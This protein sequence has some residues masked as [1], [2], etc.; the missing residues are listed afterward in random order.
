MFNCTL[1][2]SLCISVSSLACW[3]S[4]VSGSREYRFTLISFLPSSLYLT[5][6]WNENDEN[7]PHIHCTKPQNAQA[8]TVLWWFNKHIRTFSYQILIYEYF[9]ISLRNKSRYW[10]P[11]WSW[12][13]RQKLADGRLSSRT[14]LSISVCC[15]T[16]WV[17]M[18]SGIRWYKLVESFFKSC[19][20]FSYSTQG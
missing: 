17:S 2:T 6:W 19:L 9:T 10:C 14:S 4:M 18:V 11:V 15:L 16:N 7:K 3:L 1:N 20:Y 13:M 5:L 12:E 8:E